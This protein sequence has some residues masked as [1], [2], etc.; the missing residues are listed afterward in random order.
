MMHTYAL[1]HI[2]RLEP[3]A[4]GEQPKPGRTCAKLNQNENP[5]PPSPAVLEALRSMP[6]ESLRRYP[7]PSAGALRAA[8]AERTGL[9]AE[10]IYCANGSSEIISLLFKVFVGPGGRAAVAEPG[11]GLYQTEAAG[12]Q[13]A[14]IPIPLLPDYRLDIDGLLSS[15][16]DALILIHP[17]APTGLLTNPEELERLV[18]SFQGLVV[19]DEA[20]I[21][22]A[23]AGSSVLPLIEQFPNL[24]VLRTFS[25]SYG[26][27]GLRAGYCAGSRELI[28]AFAKGGGIYNVD[29][30]AQKLALAAVRD[31][32][33][34]R[35]S[36]ARVV[37]TRDAFAG[38]LRRRGYD[39]LPSS[40]N[41]V[42]CAPPVT[43]PDARTIYR[44]LVERDIYVRHYE[45]PRLRGLLR[46]SI[47]TDEEME[48][49]RRE[50]DAL[51]SNSG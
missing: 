39:V 49:L 15:G 46:I 13:A 21:D 31:D 30:L 35:G 16:A 48:W 34:M 24:L 9:A 11:F 29:A 25:K 28:A 1:P 41:F 33:Y 42:L 37:A 18:R 51:A 43:G 32:A 7:D 3:Y 6:E 5:Y 14:C 26:L 19:V 40:A 50:L 44:K 36:V 10:Q 20:Y 8:I 27:S 47:G 17:H 2:E 23:P 12:H 38:E 22:Y 45:H 4:L